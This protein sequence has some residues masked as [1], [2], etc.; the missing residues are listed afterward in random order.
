MATYAVGDLQGC[1]APLQCLL[2]EVEFNPCSDRLWLVGDLVNRGPHS[3]ETLRFIKSLGD[4]AITVL[5]NHD[6]H[7]LAIY[8]GVRSPST[9]LRDI[10]DAPDVDELMLW[11][12]QQPLLHVDRDLKMAMSHAGIL[13]TWSLTQAQSLAGEVEA[14]LRG[15]RSEL[16]YFFKTMYGNEPR[17][18]KD[19]LEGEQRLRVIVNVLTRM[20]LCTA[21]GKLDLETS[22]AATSDNPKY[23]P[24]FSYPNPALD[25]IEWV[26]GHWAALQGNVDVPGIY[27]LDTGCVWGGAMTMMRLEDKQRFTCQ[28]DNGGGV[29]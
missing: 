22:D 1:L 4:S 6:L 19:E 17:R 8:F 11:L 7:L 16:P 12:R 14:I 26:F 15:P 10:I 21:R 24:W 28:C 23:A 2:R 25:D 5:G 29:Q 18:W 27:G 3:L 20:R 13:P 9:S